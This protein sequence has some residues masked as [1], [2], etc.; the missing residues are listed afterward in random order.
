MKSYLSRAATVLFASIAVSVAGPN[1]AALEAKD[2][3]AWQAFRDKNAAEFKKVVG[4]NVVAVY[5]DGVADMQKEMADMQK[6]D[7]KSFAISDYK[8]TMSGSDTAVA[9]YVVK[10]EGTMA[11]QDASG[12]MNAA[13]VWKESNGGWQAIFH[14]NIAQASATK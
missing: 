1:D 7:M 6:W 12:T 9:T 5:N 14:T 10:V 13:S 4:P 8:V 2:K 3:A 11:G